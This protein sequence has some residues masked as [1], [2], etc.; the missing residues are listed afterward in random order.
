MQVV[1]VSILSATMQRPAANHSLGV[2]NV[3]KSSKLVAVSVGSMGSAGCGGFGFTG[4]LA[5]ALASIFGA[6]FFGSS[7]ALLG[8]FGGLEGPGAGAGGP[9]KLLRM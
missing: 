4:A 6:L 2:Q 9:A 5:T 7:A 8:A 1:V 3:S